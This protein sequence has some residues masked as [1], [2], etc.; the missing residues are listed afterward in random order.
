MVFRITIMAVSKRGG[1]ASMSGATKV[2]ISVEPKLLV[3]ID[4]YADE[5]GMTRSGFIS[6]AVKKYL[7]AEETLPSMT[8][9]ISKLAELM[10]ERTGMTLEEKAEVVDALQD[11]ADRIMGKK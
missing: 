4:S 3:R 7:E 5:N 8:K 10:S 1:N 11:S 9:V 6:L 2:T